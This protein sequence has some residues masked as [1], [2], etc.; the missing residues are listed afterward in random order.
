MY[1]RPQKTRKAGYNKITSE[2]T[3]REQSEKMNKEFD[4][5]NLVQ[6]AREAGDIQEAVRRIDLFMKIS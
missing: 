1:R 2:E 5:L 4:L 3:S 6:N